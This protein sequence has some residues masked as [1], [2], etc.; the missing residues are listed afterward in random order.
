MKRGENL[1]KLLLFVIFVIVVFNI[2]DVFLGKNSFFRMVK[3]KEDLE[4]LNK[5]VLILKKEN[6]KLQKEYFELKELESGQ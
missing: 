3:L 5:K 2:V 4:V 1:Q 6:A